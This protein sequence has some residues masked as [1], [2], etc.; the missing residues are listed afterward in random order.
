M[1]QIIKFLKFGKVEEKEDCL[2][3]L[4]DM[5]TRI[6]G[7]NEFDIFYNNYFNKKKI[8]QENKD[9]IYN[10]QNPSDDYLHKYNWIILTINSHDSQ[11]KFEGWDV[12]DTVPKDFYNF[13]FRKL[14]IEN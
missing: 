10:P 6:G 13:Y 11:N 2:E 4:M 3:F 12:C 5:F 9:N 14:K 8:E 7:C 1:I